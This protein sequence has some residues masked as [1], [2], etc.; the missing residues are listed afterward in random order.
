MKRTLLTLLLSVIVILSS[1]KSH[2]QDV[3]GGQ[4]ASN[5]YPFFVSLTEPIAWGPPF[6]PFCG[7]ALIK[8]QW[9][10]TA[11]H[12]VLDFGTG[13]NADSIDILINLY[14]LSNPNPT[15]QRITSDYIIR[16]PHFDVS[17][18]SLLGDLA[19]IHLKTPA[20]VYP[21]NLI[22]TND[23]QYEMPFNNIDVVGFG[24]YDTTNWNLQPDTLQIA[25]IK[26]IPNTIANAFDRY[27]GEIDTTMI[28]AGR[29]DTSAK[30]AAAGDSGGPLFDTDSLGNR[31]QIGIVSFGNGAHSTS[32]HPGVYTRVSAYRKWIDDS[33]FNYET[34]TGVNNQKKKEFTLKQTSSTLEIVLPSLTSE[35]YTIT[36]SDVNGKIVYTT[37]TMKS[38]DITSFSRGMYIV[39]VSSEHTVFQAKKTVF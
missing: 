5:N 9:V 24:I 25:N 34:G 16:H 19:L 39:N 20:N 31:I 14:S 28:C 12:C 26:V 23:R 29:I 30:G 21:I 37:N 22:D 2:A 13:Q 33:I 35:K 38:I 11:A 3:V 6:S 15:Y 18:R 36:I 27:N 4:T 7:G 1:K 10:L 8:S 32:Q 17:G